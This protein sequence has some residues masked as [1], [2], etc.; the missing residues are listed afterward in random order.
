[1]SSS[2]T[3]LYNKAVLAIYW[4]NKFIKEDTKTVVFYGNTNKNETE[5]IEFINLL[6]INVI[7]INIRSNSADV[8]S[9]YPH[10]LHSQ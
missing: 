4:F 2:P 3:M 10:C 1:M 8:L 9:S 5:F 6:G 7:V